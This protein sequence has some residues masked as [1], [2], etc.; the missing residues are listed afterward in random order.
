MSF[1]IPSLVTFFRA[2]GEYVAPCSHVSVLI[3]VGR[4]HGLLAVDIKGI[5]IELS[6]KRLC[7]VCPK[8]VVL[9]QCHLAD[10][11]RYHFA[12]TSHD[13]L[14]LVWQEVSADFYSD[15]LGIV[16]PEGDGA[17]TTYMLFESRNPPVFLFSK[18]TN[19]PSHQ[20][21]PHTVSVF[22]MTSVSRKNNTAYSTSSFPLMVF[23][24][25]SSPFHP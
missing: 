24:L 8:S 9:F 17:L 23:P 5:C 22:L 2:D 15:C 13:G 10:Y 16:V 12:V 18:E 6:F 7:S 20:P 11:L 14:F 19:F 25:H 3:Y 21:F 1:V 4:V